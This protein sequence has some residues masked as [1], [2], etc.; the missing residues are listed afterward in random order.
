VSTKQ[1]HGQA[2]RIHDRRPETRDLRDENA[3]WR[4]WR[5]HP[6]TSPL[7]KVVQF[8]AAKMTCK[9]CT[10]KIPYAT[11]VAAMQRGT[12]ADYC[13][14]SHRATAKKRRQRSRR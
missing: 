13:S 14:P 8:L 9:H 2:Y 4:P 12:W 5:P 10:E 11:I 1:E 6:M 7:S 3:R